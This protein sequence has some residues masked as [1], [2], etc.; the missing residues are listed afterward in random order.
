MNSCKKKDTQRK[1][2]L[3]TS[4]QLKKIVGGMNKGDI[5]N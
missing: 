5:T 4:Y 3:L 2:I 1:R